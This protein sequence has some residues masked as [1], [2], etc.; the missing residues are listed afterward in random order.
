MK[1][2]LTNKEVSVEITMMFASSESWTASNMNI[3]RHDDVRIRKRN[4]K[5]IK[6]NL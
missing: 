4:Q 3:G 5:R 1:L 6:S 2:L